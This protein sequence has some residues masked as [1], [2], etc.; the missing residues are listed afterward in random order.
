[1]GNWDERDKC[2]WVA[3][4]T[5]DNGAAVITIPAVDGQAHFLT[6]FDVTYSTA[7]T[8]ALSHT[9]A[10]T[11][12]GATSPV[13]LTFSEN[14]SVRGGRFPLPG[15]LACALNTQVVFTAAASGAGGNVGWAH[16]WGAT[17]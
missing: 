10:Y 17:V 1:M 13:T 15:T 4:A 16:L 5:H 8:G 2:S 7:K 9:L 6:G 3:E 14:Y 11:P 12:P